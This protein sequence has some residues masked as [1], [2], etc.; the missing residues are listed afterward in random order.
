MQSAESIDREITA[1]IESAAARVPG[2]Q[3]HLIVFAVRRQ[4]G[5][6]GVSAT[7]KKSDLDTLAAVRH[8]ADAISRTL[9]TKLIASATCPTDIETPRINQGRRQRAGRG[10]LAITS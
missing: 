5:H 2:R 8:V 4:P 10:R 6:R 7:D 9:I 1:N 3:I